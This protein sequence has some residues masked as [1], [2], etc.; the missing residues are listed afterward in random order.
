MQRFE[1]WKEIYEELTKANKK[2]A[3]EPNELEK[4][5]LAT[6]LTGRDLESFQVMEQAHQGYLSLEKIDQASRCAFWLGLMLMMAGE[7]ARSG[8]W[9]AKGERLIENKGASE[10]SEKGLFL[11]PKALGALYSGDAPKARQLFGQAAKIGEQFGDFDLIAIGRLGLGQTLIQL[12]NVADGVKLLDETM[13]I[14]ETESVYPIATG[15]IYCAVIETC[16]MVWDLKRAHEWTSALTRWCEAQP[17]IVPF[18]G[19]C[20]IRRA[21]VIQFNGEWN[22]AL[23]EAKVAC[24]LLTRPPGEP[25]S[26]EAFYRQAELLRLL[27]DFEEAER[28]YNEAAKWGRN[29]QPGLALLRLVQGQHDLA[30]T[31][32]RNTLNETK[33]RKKRSELLPAFVHIMIATEH[34][35]EAHEAAEELC[36][37]AHTFDA[38]YL[39]ALSYYCRGA[40]FLSQSNL[41]LALEHLQK[42][43]KLWNSLHL[44][45]ESARTRELKGLVYKELHDIDNANVNLAAAKWIFE[46]LKAKPDLVRV[47]R[48]ANKKQ[49]HETHGLTLRELQVLS[50]LTSGKTNKYIAGELFISERTV[51]RHVS[52]IFN[53]LGVFSRTEA[54]AFAFKHELV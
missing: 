24:E 43:L 16:R 53:K 42:S 48:L 14:V 28:C 34:S 37:I 7:R 26:G 8:G 29:P 40:V 38:P 30:A 41:Q 13:V 4:Y 22:K 10:C 15:L 25:A 49:H 18:R 44:P 23:E 51:D 11:I 50:R 32:I 12:G 39:H 19:Q 45:Y 47:D 1:N 2:R 54:T 5:A 3:L 21:E 35:E 33:D 9:M 20:L 6:Y 46:Q 36:S 27:G 52:N 31:S 17:D